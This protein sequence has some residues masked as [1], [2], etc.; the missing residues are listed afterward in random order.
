MSTLAILA[1]LAGL[2]LIAAEVLYLYHADARGRA[3]K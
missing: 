1:A 3:Q 2:A